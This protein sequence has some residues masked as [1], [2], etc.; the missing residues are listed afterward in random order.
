MMRRLRLTITVAW[1]L[2]PLAST[3][4]FSGLFDYALFPK[5][6]W[7][8]AS[9]ALAALA[10]AR[11]GQVKLR[12]WH[13][14]F[15][16]L[17]L[18]E[19]ISVPRNR[20]MDLERIGFTA[21]IFV[22]ALWLDGAQ[23]SFQRV[24]ALIAWPAAA[25][26]LGSLLGI[27]LHTNPFSDSDVL[28]SLIGFRNWVSLFLVAAV[29]WL[30]LSRRWPA[31]LLLVTATFVVVANRTRTAW[32][33]LAV[34]LVVLAAL[35]IKRPLLRPVLLRLAAAS[36]LAIALV[37]VL[38]V[39][40]VW[41]EPQPYLSSLTSI[42]SPDTWHGR[43]RIW[44]VAL[45]MLRRHPVTG[46][47]TG[48][49][50]VAF[51]EHMLLANETVIG[52]PIFPFAMNDYLESA[53]E[54]GVAGGVL[55]LI[56]FAAWP[57]VLLWRAAQIPGR[58]GMVYVIT[59]LP[60]IGLALAA[61]A[62]SPFQRVETVVMFVCALVPLQRRLA[63]VR[64][65][66]NAIPTRIACVA[67][68]LV[69]GLFVV[70]R[71]GSSIADLSYRQTNEP[72]TLETSYR[73][74]PWGAIRDYHPI[75]VLLDHYLSAKRD[76]DAEEFVRSRVRNWPD[77]PTTMLA[78]V[79]WAKHT[80]HLDEA[81]DSLGHQLQ[82]NDQCDEMAWRVY[83]ALASQ[84][85]FP[86]DRKLPADAARA[87]IGD[88]RIPQRPEVEW[89][90]AQS[91]LEEWNGSP[92]FS[93][94]WTGSY[95][96]YQVIGDRVVPVMDKISVDPQLQLY[97]PLPV[98][99]HE[100]VVDVLDGAYDNAFDIAVFDQTA[101]TFTYVTRTPNHNEGGTCVDRARRRI[102]FRSDETER[103][104]ELGSPQRNIMSFPK[105]FAQ[106]LFDDQG[107]LYG[108]EDNRTERH[109][110]RCDADHRCRLLMAF[111]GAQSVGRL[112]LLDGHVIVSVTRAGD[113]FRHVFRIT[114]DGA[115]DP[116]PGVPSVDADILE[117]DGMEARIDR[118]SHIELVAPDDHGVPERGTVYASRVIGGIRYAIYADTHRMRTIA[119]RDGTGW[120]LLAKSEPVGG[121][122]PVEVWLPIDHGRVQAFYFGTPEAERVVL[123][124]HGG[125]LENISPRFHPYFEELNRAGFAVLAVNYPGST[126]RGASFERAFS[127]AA[128]AQTIDA[129]MS[130]LAAHHARTIVSWSV[131]TGSTI[132]DVL[133]DHRTPVSAIV[134]QAGSLPEA[135]RREAAKRN[136]PY[137]SIHGEFDVGGEAR[138]DILYPGGHD[139]LRYTDFVRIMVEVKAFLTSATADHM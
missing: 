34:Y 65:H 17:L 103:I 7:L 59:A 71:L 60:L 10:L 74:W 112:A 106:C 131:S 44:H 85:D 121:V 26:I 52:D 24:R 139:L 136:I 63:P 40:L 107:R 88:W 14:L 49:F 104:V 50:R 108:V 25:V 119:R 126:G 39:R 51:G 76:A 81:I 15:G 55:S 13:V 132:Q 4:M 18:A 19:L 70:L 105:P 16:A 133:L 120:K 68:V 37:N 115:L 84:P 35:S 101:Q 31:Q 82:L 90:Q 42:T 116:V 89:S 134:D 21:S 57:L 20:G 110:W 128:D 127:P 130:Y 87:C 66:W 92:L 6:I 78:V 67:S 56:V 29:P 61:F 80:G 72:E 45:E 11:A 123:W 98:S 43:P 32:V 48:Q 118:A 111:E 138:H 109:V 97:S 96:P 2:L 91:H 83:L 75:S 86:R 73:L 137:L 122:E 23:V 46:V 102:G 114:E 129:A 27:F 9:G 99:D 100:I 53:A 5:R 117:W 28:G 47:G 125:P 8:T 36:A 64:F 79:V 113:E 33:V 69:C 22:I 3:W 30:L 1:L 41:N 12:M 93:A 54:R 94:S 135:R 58:R 38:P 62:D 77:A 124:W 95:R